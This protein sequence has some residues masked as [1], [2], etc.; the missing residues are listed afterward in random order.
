MRKIFNKLFKKSV[1]KFIPQI[2]PW[3]DKSELIE[4]KRVIDSTYISENQLTDEFESM[5]R[6]MT[7]SKHAIAMCNGT[8]ALFACLKAMKIGLGDEVIVPNITFV[9]SSNA[10]ILAGAT[11][12]VCEIYPNTFCI[13][14]EEAQKLITPKTKAI[15][16]VHL[17]GQSADMDKIMEFATQYNIEVLEDAAQGVGVKFNGKHTGTFGKA[18]VL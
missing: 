1:R 8:M 16:P 15:M 18:G 12:V 7:G 4:L 10:I 3:I 14:V 17:Y 13:N 11:P 2:Q 5:T 9:A 6:E